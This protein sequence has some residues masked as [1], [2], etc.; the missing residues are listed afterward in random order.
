M[1]Y[2]TSSSLAL[3]GLTAMTAPIL[4]QA[5]IYV[6][7]EQAQQILFPNKALTK[8]P[9]IIT[10]DLQEKILLPLLE[11]TGKVPNK[12]LLPSEGNSSIY[13]QE[14]AESIHIKTQIFQ[15]DWSRNGKIAQ[16]IRNDKMIKECTHALFFL[17]TRSKRLE[18]TSEKIARKGKIV[19]TV[20]STYSLTMIEIETPPPVTQAS[21]HAHKSNTKIMPSLLKYQTPIQ[22]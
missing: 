15:S 5:K 8:S 11:E 13:I 7:I 10:N 18:E 20:D 3:A 14:W 9:L 17:S 12:I 16:I 22:Y 4:V 21:K 19:F 2:R 6:G 1:N